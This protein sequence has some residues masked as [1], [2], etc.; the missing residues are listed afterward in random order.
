MRTLTSIFHNHYFLIPH[1]LILQIMI[2]KNSSHISLDCSSLLLLA[3]LTREAEREICVGV[4]SGMGLTIV[5]QET[6]TY[7]HG[8]RHKPPTPMM[9]LFDYVERH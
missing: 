3:F 5:I 6:A 7:S 2:L 4:K 9:A 1:L 8:I